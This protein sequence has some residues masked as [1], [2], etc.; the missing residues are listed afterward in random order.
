MMRTF[1][2]LALSMAIALLI[3]SSITF[4]AHSQAEPTAL[5]DAAYK[6]LSQKLGQTVTRQTLPGFTWSLEKFSD[7]SLGCPQPG[8]TYAQVKTP[9]YRILIA[10]NGTVYD[11][12]AKLY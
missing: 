9:G 10:V 12:R 2:K 8:Q 5:I 3:M 4:T 11:Y 6:D 1:P 7:A